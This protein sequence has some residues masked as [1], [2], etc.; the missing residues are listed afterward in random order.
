M[1][2]RE[3][4]DNPPPLTMP[5]IL[6]LQTFESKMKGGEENKDKEGGGERGEGTALPLTEVLKT[7]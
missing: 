3:G 5:R 4:R 1:V 6:E 2:E 7:E